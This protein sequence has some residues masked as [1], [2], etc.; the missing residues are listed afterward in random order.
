MLWLLYLTL[1]LILTVVT[2]KSSRSYQVTKTVALVTTPAS[3]VRMQQSST[4]NPF[5]SSVRESL[6]SEVQ[7]TVLASRRSWRSSQPTF[8]LSP[9]T[10]NSVMVDSSTVNPSSPATSHRQIETSGFM[11]RC[12]GTNVKT[13]PDFTTTMIT[14]KASGENEASSTVSL[15]VTRV[16]PGPSS[17]VVPSHSGKTTAYCWRQTVVV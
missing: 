14:S 15:S 5:T 3:T 16:S 10:T 8:T 12:S 7:T 1:S 13:T 6:S 11:S 17:T 2:Y 9:T 4:V